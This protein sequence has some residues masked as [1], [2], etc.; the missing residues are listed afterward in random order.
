MNPRCL[1]G[2][3]GRRADSRRRRAV[4]GTRLVCANGRMRTAPKLAMPPTHAAYQGRI[5]PEKCHPCLSTDLSPMSPDHTVP[6]ESAMTIE[7]GFSN[8]YI[9]LVASE[10]GEPERA[11]LSMLDDDERSHVRG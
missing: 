11:P 2:K 5:L 7:I 4:V 6:A 10:E 1:T 8:P 3:W 9:P